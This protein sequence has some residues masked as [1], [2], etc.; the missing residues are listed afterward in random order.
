MK[1]DRQHTALFAATRVVE[2]FRWVL[3]WMLPRC[4]RNMWGSFIR[5]SY[6]L[7][8]RRTGNC[9]QELVSE[10]WIAGAFWNPWTWQ[11][12]GLGLTN[13][14]DKWKESSVFFSILLQANK[15]NP[16]RKKKLESVGWCH[17]KEATIPENCRSNSYSPISVW[18][19]GVWKIQTPESF[20]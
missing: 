14:A 3:Q 11:E 10:K 7:G 4:S 16:L 1:G 2:L 5:T 19:G 13:H 12:L 8:M 9:S 18:G 6:S 20:Y 17:Q 15:W